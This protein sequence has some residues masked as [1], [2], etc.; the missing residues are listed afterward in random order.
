MES[1]GVKKYRGFPG[2]TST[3]KGI[4][5]RNSTG[6]KTPLCKP[7]SGG[8]YGK[9]TDMLGFSGNEICWLVILGKKSILK[10]MEFTS[11]KLAGRGLS[12]IEQAGLQYMG[13]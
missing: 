11:K 7:T 2:R 8:F 3:G 1:R 13:R 5:G 10:G 4:E 12:A 6:R 9:K